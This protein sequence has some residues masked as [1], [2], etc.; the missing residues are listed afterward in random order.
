MVKNLLLC[1]V[2]ELGDNSVKNIIFHLFMFIA[3]VV[4]M[5]LVVLFSLAVANGLDLEVI[6]A[7][8]GGVSLCILITALI[9]EVIY[10]L[11][12]REGVENWLA[13]FIIIPGAILIMFFLWFML[14]LTLPALFQEL[15]DAW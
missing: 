1:R 10:F 3:A 13:L 4:S 15:V 5:G 8:G 11:V 6:G 12:N 14:F 9:F 2:D 7:F